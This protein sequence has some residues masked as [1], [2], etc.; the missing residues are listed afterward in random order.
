MLFV[1]FPPFY[2]HVWD[3]QPRVL[4]GVPSSNLNRT[5]FETMKYDDKIT[6]N[7]RFIME[8]E[9]VFPAGKI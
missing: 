6:L 5:K 7:D 1:T 9:N 8:L 3:A 4:E 2:Y